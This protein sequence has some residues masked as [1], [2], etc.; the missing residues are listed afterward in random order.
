MG[1]G[2]LRPPGR[3]KP[4]ADDIRRISP[5]GSP[6]GGR[7]AR[8]NEAKR[9]RRRVVQVDPSHGGT[10]ARVPRWGR[11]GDRLSAQASRVH[12]GPGIAGLHPAAD[13]ASR[14][15]S[16]G[17]ARPLGALVTAR[18]KLPDR[19]GSRRVHFDEATAPPPI[20]GRAPCRRFR[21]QPDG[22]HGGHADQIRRDTKGPPAQFLPYNLIRSSK[23]KLTNLS[24][25]P[26]GRCRVLGNRSYER[27]GPTEGGIDTDLVGAPEQLMQVGVSRSHREGLD[28][29]R[30]TIPT[31][32]AGGRPLRLRRE[33]DTE[34]DHLCRAGL[35][36]L[37]SSRFIAFPTGVS[38]TRVWRRP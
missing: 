15:L 14:G 9:R 3:M 7:A 37:I 11:W 20:N 28:A 24:R 13:R 32:Q 18:R 23:P 30:A 33:I 31:N 21:K 12:G 25:R 17:F 8:P 16:N 34:S 4:I 10:D 22:S 38:A 5:F 1:T 36:H 35:T 29:R 6:K 27:H 2:N 26:G 19:E